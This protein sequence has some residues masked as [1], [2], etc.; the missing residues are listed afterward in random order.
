MTIRA[1]CFDLDATLLDGSSFGPTVALTCE[2]LAASQTGLDAPALLEA[3]HRAFGS[4]W[5]GV[6]RDW[7]LGTRSGAEVSLEAWSRTLSLCGCNDPAIARLAHEIHTGLVEGALRPYPDV[8]PV[9]DHF[10]HLPCALITNGASDTQRDKLRAL[11]LENR[12]NAVVISAD[13]GIAKP[14]ARVFQMAVEAMGVMSHEALH[15]GDSL[16]A[17]VAGAKAAGLTSVWL[18]RKGAKRNDDDPEPHHEIRSLSELI[19]IV[20][21]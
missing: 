12:F 9:L 11:R 19:P 7:T 13:H 1:L 15:V 16:A 8:E 14:D 2:A 17:D 21:R 18:N 20:G 5:P 4:Y 3:N 10:G 6:E